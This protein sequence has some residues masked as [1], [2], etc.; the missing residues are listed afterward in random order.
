MCYMSAILTAYSSINSAHT[1]VYSF[2]VI[3]I[4]FKLN[5]FIVWND[6]LEHCQV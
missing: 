2:N 1:T 4:S 5:N 6:K 3:E